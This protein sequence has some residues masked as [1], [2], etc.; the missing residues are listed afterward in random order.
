MI[1]EDF[2]QGLHQEMRVL[3]EI[4]MDYIKKCVGEM[5]INLQ[6]STVLDIGCGSGNMANLLL[7]E[8]LLKEYYA[9]D[10]DDVIIYKNEKISMV[11]LNLNILQEIEKFINTNINRFDVIFLFDVVEHIVYFKYLLLNLNKLLKENG[12]I[13]IALPLDINIS[14]K[15]K[16]FIK[17]N[18]FNPFIGVHG[19]INLFSYKEIEK[20]FQQIDKLKLINIRTGLGYGL[21]D[22]KWHL[23]FLAKYFKSFTSRV[24]LL[25]KKKIEI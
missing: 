21:Y 6:N 7:K 24:Y 20:E 1:Y 8:Y 10:Y 9:V 3:H 4:N 11:R 22:K 23:D 2:N 14:T 15:I 17:G 12:H 19:H 13:I 16:L 18:L 5:G 25:Y